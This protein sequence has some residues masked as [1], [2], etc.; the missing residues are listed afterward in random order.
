MFL[1][2]VCVLNAN[3]LTHAQ[4][5]HSSAHTCRVKADLESRFVGRRKTSRVTTNP[6]PRSQADHGM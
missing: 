1:S 5:W 2:L 6:R 3:L 4:N